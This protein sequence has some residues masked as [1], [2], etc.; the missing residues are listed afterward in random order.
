MV[1]V[2]DI[3][4]IIFWMFLSVS[5]AK[6]QK[7]TISIIPELG[8][9][10]P[11]AKNIKNGFTRG[12]LV[13][14]RHWYVASYGIS[15]SYQLNEKSSMLLRFLNGQAGYSM[16]VIHNV[17]GYT[18]SYSD[19]FKASSYNEKRLILSCQTLLRIPAQSKQFKIATALQYGIGMDFRSNENE[20]GIIIFPGVNPWGE[21]FYLRDSVY[22]KSSLGLIFPLQLDLIMMS[23]S[24]KRLQLSI[25]FHLGLSKHYNVDVDYV[26]RAYEEKTTFVVRGTSLGMCLSYPLNIL[27]TGKR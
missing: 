24:K 27:M 6:A 19:R 1:S 12:N 22:N 25:F 4:I 11:F 8:V 14:N 13:N 15:A 9:Q 10:R 16:G 7:G 20:N 23:H 3:R 21:E 17:P 5:S 2:L 26:T 18:G